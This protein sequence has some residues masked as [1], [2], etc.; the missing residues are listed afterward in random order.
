[1]FVKGVGAL[2]GDSYWSESYSFIE[3]S[4]AC[5]L[6]RINLIGLFNFWVS[7]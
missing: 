7:C 6:G 5:A 3:W 2:H 1:M 4:S